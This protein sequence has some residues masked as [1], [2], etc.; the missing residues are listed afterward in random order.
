MPESFAFT[1]K[2][3]KTVQD[4]TGYSVHGFNT[5]DTN[6]EH[7]QYTKEQLCNARQRFLEGEN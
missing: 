2:P 5:S 1:D 7:Q 6:I 3:K 4:C